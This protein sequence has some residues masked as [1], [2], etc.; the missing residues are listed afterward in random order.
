MRPLALC[1]LM[2]VEGGPMLRYMDATA[3]SLHSP[4]D[5][6]RDVLS[7]PPIPGREAPRDK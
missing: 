6:L 3:R 2:T 7:T 5:Y 1:L 4:A